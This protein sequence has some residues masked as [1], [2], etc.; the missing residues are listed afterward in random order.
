MTRR[1]RQ[2]AWLPGVLL[3][4]LAPVLLGHVAPAGGGPV[5]NVVSIVDGDTIRIRVDGR[6]ESVRYIGIDAP[7]ARH[8]ARCAEP[9]AREATAVNRR[10]VKNR[11]VMLERDV[12]ER[13]RYGRLLAYVYV[14]GVMINAE[15]VRLGHARV[16]TVPPNVRHATAFLALERQAR[17]AGRGL[18]AAGWTDAAPACEDPRAPDT[19]AAI[20]RARR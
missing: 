6:V 18:W 16:M 17:A 11:T 12:Q 15:L 5:A 2:R 7:D 3:S 4:A 10:L 19:S 14:D 1:R 20:D 9:G 8:P 13:D